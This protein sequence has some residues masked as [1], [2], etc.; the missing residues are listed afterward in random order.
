IQI[1]RHRVASCP[2]DQLSEKRLAPDGKK[3]LLRNLQ[4]YFQPW[5]WIWRNYLRSP[6]LFFNRSNAPI[7]L[8]GGRARY[9]GR[10]EYLSNFANRLWNIVHTANIDHEERNMLLI[11]HVCIGF[12][13]RIG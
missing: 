3:R 4:K 6:R 12:E 1:F 8:V 11:E 7:E 13:L 5:S 9:I 2:I 10:T